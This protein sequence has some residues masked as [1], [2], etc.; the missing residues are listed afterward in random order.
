VKPFKRGRLGIARRSSGSE[1]LRD[2]DRPGNILVAAED[3]ATGAR[4]LGGTPRCSYPGTPRTSLWLTDV[5]RRAVRRPPDRSGSAGRARPAAL[6]TGPRLL[7]LDEPASGRTSTR[8]RSV[9]E[10]LT[11]LAREGLAI[12]H[13]GARH[14]PSCR[15]SER[16]LR[17]DFGRRHRP[18]ATQTTCD[19]TGRPTGLPRHRR[20]RHPRGARETSCGGSS[21]RCAASHPCR[22]SPPSVPAPRTRA[23]ARADDLVSFQI[24]TAARPARAFQDD[25]SG[26]RSAEVDVPRRPPT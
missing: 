14:R 3:P 4:A 1:V 12:L 10:L 26:A 13:R 17:L 7:L 16:G 22:A 18:A 11:I 9:G 21:R 20:R 6:R 23:T 25:G 24:S 8:R 5:G 15:G 2:D 19:R